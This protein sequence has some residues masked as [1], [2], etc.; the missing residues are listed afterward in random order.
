[1]PQEPDL[2]TLSEAIKQSEHQMSLF[3][4]KDFPEE[5]RLHRALMAAA[6]AYRQERWEIGR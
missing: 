4:E 3:P 2:E 5:H 6:R 1:M